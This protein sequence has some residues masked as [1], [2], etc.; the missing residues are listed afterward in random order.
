MA[1]LQAHTPSQPAEPRGRGEGADKGRACR[2]RDTGHP[3][4]ARPPRSGF[5]ICINTHDSLAATSPPCLVQLPSPGKGL[6]WAR[7]ACVQQGPIYIRPARRDTYPLC[8]RIGH[9]RFLRKPESRSTLVVGQGGHPGGGHEA[10]PP[11]PQTNP[12]QLACGGC[13]S[14]WPSAC[15]RCRRCR[16]PGPRPPVGNTRPSSSR[17]SGREQQKHKGF[18][19]A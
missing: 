4:D 15:S 18:I 13:R 11:R 7:G 14:A 9:T 16:C 3:A 10:P 19:P 5:Q 8:Y 6:G 17:W 1:L 12:Q 2:Q